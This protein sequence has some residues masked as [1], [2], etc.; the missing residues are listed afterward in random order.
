M[1]LN[2]HCNDLS[3]QNN[4]INTLSSKGLGVTNNG[5][6]FFAGVGMSIN[7]NALYLMRHAETFGTQNHQFMS[8]N[9]SN[10]HISLKGKQDIANLNNHLE[11]YNFDYIIVCC[12]IPRVL[13]TAFELKSLY[14]KMNYIHINNV[15]GI[16]NGGWE[17]K[18]PQNLTG[19][20]LSDYIEREVNK[21]IFAKSSRGGSWGEVL[22]NTVFLINYINSNLSH[23]RIL[24]ISQGSILQG[25]KIIT[26][27]DKSPWGN[28]DSKKMYNLDK[29]QTI[30]N[31]GKIVRIYDNCI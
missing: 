6:I 11:K 30:S 16:N 25:L 7:A 22:L 1:K 4:I 27:T 17:G 2:Y 5:K 15:Y 31:Y 20:D 9:S 19:I 12:D 23:K 29:K 8:N 18:T 3:T 13:E 26:H 28:Y 24:L 21:N 14:P 10:S